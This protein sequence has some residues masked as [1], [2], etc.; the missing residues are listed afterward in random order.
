MRHS[1][2]KLRSIAIFAFGTIL[3][4]CGTMRA[5][6]AGQGGRLDIQTLSYRLATAPGQA[7]ASSDD[8]N[9]SRKASTWEFSFKDPAQT[10]AAMT[11]SVNSVPPGYESAQLEFSVPFYWVALPKIPMIAAVVNDEHYAQGTQDFLRDIIGIENKS[12]PDIFLF[13]QRAR[14]I[15]KARYDDLQT[16]SRSANEDD[17]RVAYWLLYTS[18]ELVEKRLMVVDAITRLARDWITQQ[19]D[20]TGSRTRLFKKGTVEIG[21]LNDVVSV[22]D[23]RDSIVYNFVIQ[24][25]S[26]LL[27]S[28][29]ENT[30]SDACGKIMTTRSAFINILPEDLANYN[31][32]FANSV[33][34][35]T[36]AVIC[37]TRKV[38]QLRAGGGTIPPAALAEAQDVA[39]SAQDAISAV[40]NVS[41]WS[42]EIQVASSRITELSALLN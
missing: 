7:N 16:R 23:H 21:T 29:D 34:I 40:A 32:N 39:K 8:L 10:L 41:K 22:L 14:H 9:L 28:T 6:Q 36:D 25:L 33:L 17:I 15:F 42:R 26:A 24:K 2:A 31:G 18:R 35:H 5:A 11:I 20:D 12:V 27:Q 37:A 3:I 19:A 4:S 1:Q 13:N 30:L 38:R